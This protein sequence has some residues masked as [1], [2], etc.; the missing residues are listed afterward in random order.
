[1]SVLAI[2]VNSPALSDLS[3]TQVRELAALMRREGA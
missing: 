1:M 2:S 3:I